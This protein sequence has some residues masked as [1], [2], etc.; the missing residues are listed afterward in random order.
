MNK[1]KN[2][3]FTIVELVVVITVIAILASV[4]TIAYRNVQASARDEKRKSDV[5]I[6]LAAVEEYYADYGDYPVA[7]PTCPSPGSVDEC[8][9]NEIW[10]ML[11]DQGY[12]ARIPTADA[13]SPIAAHNVSGGKANYGWIRTSNTRFGIYVPLET[14]PHKH[15]K[16]GKNMVANWW[17]STPTCNF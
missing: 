14:H 3:G 4:T 7:S 12:L 11:V 17:S 9:R 2:F 15:C 5:M 6:L 13:V 16:T 1:R 10:Q 8:H